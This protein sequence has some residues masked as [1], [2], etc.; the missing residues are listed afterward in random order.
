M[1]V[2]RY[3]SIIPPDSINWAALNKKNFP[4]LIK[5]RQGDDNS[6][7]V[8]KFNFRNKYDVYLHDTN[9]RGL[10]NR[11][12]RAMSHGC[13]RVQRWDSLAKYLTVTDTLKH[14]PDSIRQ[15]IGRGEK[16]V[17]VLREKV[18]IYLRYFT[19]QAKEDQLLFFEDIY[20]EDKLLRNRYLRP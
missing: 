6:L 12:N 5:Q 10:F 3:D 11:T 16:K 4:Y 9:A 2:D 15:W 18:P 13:V 19:V 14:H 1:V 8:I 7:G 17:V 20:G